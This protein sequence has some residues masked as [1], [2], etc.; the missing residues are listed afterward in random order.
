VAAKH[1]KPAAG[2][3][4]GPWIT[5]ILTP[6][7]R[8]K[9]LQECEKTLGFNVLCAFAYAAPSYDDQVLSLEHDLARRFRCG[10]PLMMSPDPRVIKGRASAKAGCI[11]MANVPTAWKQYELLRN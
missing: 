5:G 4:D 7:S 8:A 2:G 11:G 10:G 9:Y 6:S 3:I 1:R